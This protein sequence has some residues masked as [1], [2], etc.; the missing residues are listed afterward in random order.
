VSAPD[1]APPV[2]VWFEARG[3]YLCQCGCD[4]DPGELAAWIPG[5][6]DGDGAVVCLTCG[7]AAEQEAVV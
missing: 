4:V 1:V 2:V 7:D 6:D 3:A 5:G